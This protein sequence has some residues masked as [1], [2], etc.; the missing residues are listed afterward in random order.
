[1]CVWVAQWVCLLQGYVCVCWDECKWGSDGQGL[2]P[3]Y[4]YVV[5]SLCVITIQSSVMS[6]VLNH[7]IGKRNGWYG[8][9]W[10]I[11]GDKASKYQYRRSEIPLHNGLYLK[12]WLQG[13]RGSWGDSLA[14][15]QVS[16]CLLLLGSITGLF[17]F[18]FFFWSNGN[19]F[20]AFFGQFPFFSIICLMIEA[21]YGI[22]SLLVTASA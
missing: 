8:R 12:S 6:N 2:C 7:G 13:L 11:L 4:V 9:Y 22:S 17:F 14:Y 5:C 19:C 16:I 15:S 18:A 3:L 1:M 10:S 21:A 20:F